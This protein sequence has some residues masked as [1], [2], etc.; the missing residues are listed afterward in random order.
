M[1]YKLININIY[2]TIS[3]LYNSLTHILCKYYV[4]NKA[5]YHVAYM[6]F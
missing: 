4:N 6:Y 5:Q 2:N 3:A 1:Y